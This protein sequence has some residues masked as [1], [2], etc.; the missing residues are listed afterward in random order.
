MLLFCSLNYAIAGDSGTW[1]ADLSFS[2]EFYM[3]KLGPVST[4]QTNYNYH[5]N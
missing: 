3:Q 2:A 5:L 4:V 1:T